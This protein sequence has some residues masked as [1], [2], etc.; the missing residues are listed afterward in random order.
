MYSFENGISMVST[1]LTYVDVSKLTSNE[2]DEIDEIVVQSLYRGGF[3]KS[4]QYELDEDENV[5]VEGI[6]GETYVI[7]INT[8]LVFTIDF[9]K[10]NKIKQKILQIKKLEQELI[11]LCDSSN[12]EAEFEF[13]NFLVYYGGI[14]LGS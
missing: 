4:N 12:G 2:I 6:D 5:V 1:I 7:F 10:L 13:L 8:S 11:E 14:H 9:K 3:I